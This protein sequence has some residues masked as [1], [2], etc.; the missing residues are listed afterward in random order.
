MNINITQLRSDGANDSAILDL[1]QL[2]QLGMVPG[3]CSV[4]RLQ[5]LW[6]CHQSTVSRRMGAVA[7]LGV[8]TVRNTWGGYMVSPERSPEAAAARRWEALRRRWREGVTHG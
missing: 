2:R 7:D 3:R 5:E 1:L 8:C 6:S 4:Q